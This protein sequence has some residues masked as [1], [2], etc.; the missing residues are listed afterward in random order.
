MNLRLELGNDS[1]VNSKY[2]TINN[3][4]DYPIKGKYNDQ[5]TKYIIFIS[6]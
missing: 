4:N 1:K 6:K 5:K 2:S 3:N